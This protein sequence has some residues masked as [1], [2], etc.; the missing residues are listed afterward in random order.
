MFFS[1][2]CSP[3]SGGGLVSDPSIQISCSAIAGN[4]TST[5]C[6]KLITVHKQILLLTTVKNIF[7]KNEKS[8][9]ELLSEFAEQQLKEH[10]QELQT[11]YQ[12]RELASTGEKTKA[13]SEHAK[14]F[15][16]ELNIKLNELKENYQDEVSEM[17]E[18]VK[19]FSAK[20]NESKADK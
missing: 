3:L 7:M 11:N 12:G 15:Q 5:L 9:K 14:L 1:H 19:K 6:V 2:I 10:Q 8:G 18:M 4:S 17:E 13:Y 20:L 16:S